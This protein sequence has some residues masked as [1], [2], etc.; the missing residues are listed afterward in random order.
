MTKKSASTTGK[1]VSLKDAR[2]LAGRM[3]S[4]DGVF[5]TDIKLLTQV[6]DAMHGLL[7]EAHELRKERARMDFIVERG[8][9]WYPGRARDG[10]GN[11]ILCYQE[12]SRR[13]EAVGATMRDAL[14][15]AMADVRKRQRVRAASQQQ[16]LSGPETER[17]LTAAIEA[18]LDA[19][20]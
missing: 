14:D 5:S 10:S 7:D 13:M 20:Y 6:R 4:E 11:G 9:T 2:T 3:S 12:G 19:T 16:G 15:A 18:A 1:P 17:H 8:T